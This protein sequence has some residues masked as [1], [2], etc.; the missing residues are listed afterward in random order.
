MKPLSLILMISLCRACASA[1]TG[2]CL[3][4]EL[5]SK[6]GRPALTNGADT[7]Q[8]G[9]LELEYGLERSWGTG[10]R[11]TS[12][13]GGL[14]FGIT[15]DIDFHWTAGDFLNV[16]DQDGDHTGYGD[17]WFG[18]SYRYRKQT[19]SGPSLGVIYMGKIPTGDPSKGLSSGEVDHT[20]AFL[21][22]KDISRLHV[23]FNAGPQW[24]GMAH[25]ASD[26]N[27]ALS[28]AASYPATGR[29]TLVLEAYGETAANADTPGYAALMTGCSIQVNPRLYLD[30]GFDNGITARAPGKRLFAGITV[31]VVNAYRWLSPRRM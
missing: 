6:P 9:V 7:T 20:L 26:Y 30:A 5:V 29:I 18:F 13:A 10:F 3:D 27:V 11:G 22:S 19:K 31:A 23:D 1:Q 17:N 21:V 8:C 15:P 28:M 24:M 12:V 4:G 25:V 2:A 16:A 14:R